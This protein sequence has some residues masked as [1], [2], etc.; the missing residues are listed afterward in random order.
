MPA[1]PRR[2]QPQPPPPYGRQPAANRP[3]RPPHLRVSLGEAQRRRRPRQLRSCAPPATSPACSCSRRNGAPTRHGRAAVAAP[4]EQHQRVA[5]AQRLLRSLQERQ[6]VEEE[7]QREAARHGTRRHEGDERGASGRQGRARRRGA[8]GR[9]HVVVGGGGGGAATGFRVACRA[10]HRVGGARVRLHAAT[11]N[12]C[13]ARG[14]RAKGTAFTVRRGDHHTLHRMC[15]MFGITL[16]GAGLA[17]LYLR[18]NDEQHVQPRHHP[19]GLKPQRASP[20]IHGPLPVRP[21]PC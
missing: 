17:C 15:A 18:P 1:E 13:I 21:S 11:R 5:A 6:A 7:R 16:T 4:L 8:D 3:A 14:P 19:T 9:L 12:A 20:P 10:M 2:R